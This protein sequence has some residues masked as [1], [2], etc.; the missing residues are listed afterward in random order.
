MKLALDSKNKLSFI[1]G[2]LPQPLPGDSMYHPWKRCNTMIL[3]WIQHSVE[4]SIVKSILWMNSAAEVWKDLQERFYQGDMFRIAELLEVFYRLNQGNLTISEFYTQLKSIWEEIEEFT[5]IP[6]CKYATSC[7]CGVIQCAKT[8]R[9]Q[10]YVIRFLKG[11]NEQYAHVRSQIMVLDPLPNISKTFFLLIQQERQFSLLT[12]PT[13]EVETRI[14]HINSK[15]EPLPRNPSNTTIS[16]PRGRGGYTYRGRGN[17][18]NGP[19][20]SQGNKFCTFY[21]RTNHTIETCFLKHGYPP[22]YQ[23]NKPTRMVNHTTGFPMDKE[24]TTDHDFPTP[25][26]NTRTFTEDQMQ[27]ILDLLQQ[28]KKGAIPSTLQ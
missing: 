21:E 4:E 1:D 28:S 23:S 5:S 3:S 22:G 25:Q 16:T 7:T 12:L 17:R 18:K 19:N 24:D 14:L 27:G 13:L 26:A 2:S 6:N 20:R 8:Y 15:Q 10:T 9:E 11:V